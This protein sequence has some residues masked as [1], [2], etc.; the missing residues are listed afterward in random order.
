MNTK[1]ELVP[2]PRQNTDTHTAFYYNG[3]NDNILGFS[4]VISM[5]WH[6]G[7]Y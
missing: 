5:F 2:K 3:S 4:T 1:L 6:S 7:W